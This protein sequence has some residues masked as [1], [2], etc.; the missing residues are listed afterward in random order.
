MPKVNED[1]LRWA[2]ETAGLTIEDAANKLDIS[3]A[4]EMTAADRLGMLEEGE[5]D[6]TR[7]MLIKMSKQYHRPLLTFYMST[8]PQRGDHGED[9]RTLPDDYSVVDNALLDAL[10]RDVRARQSIIRS[11]MEEEEED[12]VLPLVG[13]MR[14]SDGVSDVLAS[15]RQII[16]IDLTD[17][18]SQSSPEAA[19]ALLRSGVEAAGIF[20]LLISNLGSHHSSITLETFRGFTIA[21]DIAPFI[22]IND[23]D[24]KA[25][26][27]FTLLH[28]LTHILLGQ[29]GISGLDC[30]KTIEQFCNDVASEFLLPSRELDLLDINNSASFET[31]ESCISK[32]ANQRNISSSMV[33]YNLFRKGFIS[34]NMWRTLSNAYRKYWLRNKEKS[35][36]KARESKKKGPDYYTVHQYRVGGALIV[37]VHRMMVSG[38]LTTSKAGKVLG[39]RAKN[40]MP[41]VDT[42]GPGSFQKRV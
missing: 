16:Q 1:I 31:A 9:F 26:L 33:T 36:L 42:Q 39:V 3:D 15:I 21:D 41:L 14:M 2:R 22:I 30:E 40:V 4:R 6:P 19:F 7:P 27:S 5:S 23:Q 13:S 24:S 8:P 37:L 32:F 11:A 35:R 17:F 34:E 12:T 20:V 25:A 18:H 28:E 29:S 38:A 10:I